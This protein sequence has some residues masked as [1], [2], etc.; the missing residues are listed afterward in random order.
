MASLPALF[1]DIS[2]GGFPSTLF[3][4][5]RGDA[6]PIPSPYPIRPHVHFLCPQFRKLNKVKNTLDVKVLRNGD[7]ALVPGSDIMVGDLLVL[8]AGDKVCADGVFVR[9]EGG[10]VQL[11]ESALTGESK[12]VR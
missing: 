11:D 10:E 8:E 3:A 12:P 1:F 4:F 6:S 5:A 2:E 9:G 7:E